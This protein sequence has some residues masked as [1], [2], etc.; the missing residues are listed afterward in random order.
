[1]YILDSSLVSIGI[2][3]L[4]F[5]MICLFFGF[6][7]FWLFKQLKFKKGKFKYALFYTLVLFMLFLGVSLLFRL[8][9]GESDLLILQI[10][11]DL[12]AGF[13]LLKEIYR[14]SNRTSLKGFILSMLITALLLMIYP[15]VILIL[16]A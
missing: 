5:I 15:L 13:Y 8:V 4:I 2:L 10:P 7:N 11:I 1:M 12:L 9:L 14:E 16:S 3:G 6:L